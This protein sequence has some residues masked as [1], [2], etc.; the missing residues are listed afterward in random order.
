[1]GNID[2]GTKKYAWMVIFKRDNA[3]EPIFHRSFTLDWDQDMDEDKEA[4]LDDAGDEHKDK[5]KDK[6]KTDEDDNNGQN[7]WTVS[8]GNK[9]VEVNKMTSNRFFF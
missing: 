3:G 7:K 4:E 2:H 8:N 1:M 5:D 9:R 6:D